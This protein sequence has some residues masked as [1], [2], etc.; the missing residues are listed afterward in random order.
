MRLKSAIRFC[1]PLLLLCLTLPAAQANVYF[2][3]SRVVFDA[4]SREQS[5][6]IVNRNRYPVLIQAWIDDGALNSTAASFKDSPVITYPPVF[7]LGAQENYN[8]RLINTAV[9]QKADSKEHLYWLNIQIV[10][11][12]NGQASVSSQPELNVSIL[13]KFKLFYRPHAL[14]GPVAEAIKEMHFQRLAAAQLQIINP[15]P[16][17]V[18]FKQIGAD[19]VAFLQNIMLPP[20]GSQ[21]LPTLAPLSDSLP[22]LDYAVLNDDGAVAT[23]KMPLVR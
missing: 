8:I 23:G 5:F 2:S 1:L 6:L 7:K 15:T 10:S 11:P 22:A 4:G 12:K 19:G 14:K 21:T 17:Y 9:N 3:A 18:T 20:G 16:Y 13:M